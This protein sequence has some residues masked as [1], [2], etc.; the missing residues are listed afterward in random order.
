MKMA[1]VQANVVISEAW[2]EIL[3]DDGD[4]ASFALVILEWRKAGTDG[5]QAPP[6]TVKKLRPDLPALLPL[7]RGGDRRRPLGPGVG[8][9]PGARRRSP[10]RSRLP[11]AS[12]GSTTTFTVA[13]PCGAVCT[14]DTATDGC[15]VFS[16]LVPQGTSVSGPTFTTHP[17]EGLGLVN[18]AGT[19][20]ETVNTALGTG[21]IVSSHR[22]P[23]GTP[24]LGLPRGPLDAALQRQRGHASGVWETGIACAD[25]SGTLSDYWNSSVTFSANASDPIGFVWTGP[26]GVPGPRLRP[27]PCRARSRSPSPGPTRPVTADPLSQAT[28][29]T[30]P[31]PIPRRRRAPERHRQRSGGDVGHGERD[32]R[33]E[34]LFL[35][36]D[37]RQRPG[38]VGRLGPRHQATRHHDHDRRVQAQE[39][40]CGHAGHLHGQGQGHHHGVGRADRDRVVDRRFRRLRKRRRLHAE[41]GDVL[42]DLHAVDRATATVTGTYSGSSAQKASAGSGKLKVS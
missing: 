5:R 24:R 31:W 23:M 37:R 32:Q 12:G 33:E 35:R 15:H 28:T 6:A 7:V 29:S 39:G 38:P 3:Q 20:Y 30:A 18:N 34:H 25:S 1:R 8:L 27:R 10:T 26:P 36:G 14:G 41:R 16:Y 2:G 22:P 21:E 40:G 9:H 4:G 17:S 11:L 42:G 13:L 19:Y